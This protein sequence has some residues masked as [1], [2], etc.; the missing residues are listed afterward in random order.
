MSVV[1]LREDFPRQSLIPATDVFSFYCCDLNGVS[2]AGSSFQHEEV[3]GSS[4]PVLKMVVSPFVFDLYSRLYLMLMSP[5]S[6]GGCTST[7][8]SAPSAIGLG[9]FGFGG[10]MGAE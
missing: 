4:S 3:R 2:I 9:G 8:W 6:Y 1:R 5:F 10:Q 7:A